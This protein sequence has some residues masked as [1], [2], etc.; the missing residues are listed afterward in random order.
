MIK[1]RTNWA[2]RT[3]AAVMTAC[4]VLTTPGL[5]RAENVTS[6][7]Y[8]TQETANSDVEA[9]E[10]TADT[11]EEYTGSSEADTTEKY[12]GGSEAD[13]TEIDTDEPGTE[14][15]E[16]DT[17]EEG[18][19]EED[20]TEDITEENTTEEDTAEDTT[21]EDT[22]E[23]I[24]EEGTTE[25]DTA[26]NITEEDITE[27]PDSEQDAPDSQQSAELADV[28][29]PSLTLEAAVSMS[30]NKLT[31]SDQE[32]RVNDGIGLLLLSNVIPADYKN[33]VI[34]LVT[35]SGWDV[36]K[37][38]KVGGKE[39]SFLGLGS[40]DV[41]FEGTFKIDASTA[42][43]NYSI[44]TNRTLFNA[45]S[46]KAV[47]GKLSISISAEYHTIDGA[48]L[49]AVLKADAAEDGQSTLNS[50]IVLR[51]GGTDPI[52]EAIVG[53]GMIGTMEAGTSAN[54][55]FENTLTCDLRIS[56]TDNVG[57]FCNTME[58]GASL[59]AEYKK[60]AV[61]G[62]VSVETTGTDKNAGG[63]VGYM[64]TGTNLIIA[65]AS[66]NEVRSK[67][68]NAGGIVGSVIDG[69]LTVKQADGG[70]STPGFAF[71]DTLTLYAGDKSTPDNQKSA[72]GLI[73]YYEISENGEPIEF[74][75]SRYTFRK[76]EVNC[77]NATEGIAFVGGLFGSLIN[78]C[79]AERNISI[80]SA[81]A[82]TINTTLQTKV[83]DLGGMIGQ[84]TAAS[85]ESTLA[86]KGSADT[87]K[88]INVVTD[89]A[90]KINSNYG[91]II[92]EIDNNAYVEIDDVYASTTNIGS[93]S[94]AAFGGLIGRIKNGLLNA[95]NVTL[96]S[97]TDI[98]VDN[99]IGRGGLVG[100]IEKGVLRL[101]GTTDL[102]GQKITTA[103]N[104]TG[105]IV[106]NNENGLIY[107]VGDGNA[108]T[109]GGNGWSL[110][111]YNGADRG[112]SD[113]GNWGAVVRLGGNLTEGDAGVLSFGQDT[114]TVTIHSGTGADIKNANEFAAYALAFDISSEYSGS[115]G[116]LNFDSIVDK[117]KTQTVALSGD[118]YLTGTGIVGIGKDSETQMFKGAFDGGNH[119]ITLDI[120]TAYGK[121]ELDNATAA[122][123]MYVK[124]SDQR[125]AHYS[126]AMIPFSK[127]VTVS[128]VIIDGKINCSISKNVSQTTDERWPAFVSSVLGLASGTTTL[129]NVI[130]RTGI[131]VTE[132]MNAPKFNIW[133]SG[134]VGRC[135]GTKLDVTNCTW[136]SSSSLS[137][138]RDK[139]EH[140]IGGLA[141]EVMGG[142]TVTVKN[143]TL[144]GTITSKST[145][146][147]FVGG[148]IAVSRGETEGKINN[149][150][151]TIK[152]SNVK[153]D[154][155]KI[156]A[157]ATSTCGGLLGY[158]WQNTNVVFETEENTGGVT[159]SGSTLTAQSAQFGGLVYQAS[160]YWNATARDS[161]VFKKDGKGNGNTFTGKS[162]KDNTSGLLVGTGIVKFTQNNREIT[163]AMYLEAGTWGTGSDDS[164]YKINKDAVTLD[165]GSSDY[166]DE[167]VGITEDDETGS[168]N[169][170][171]SLAVRDSSG[172]AVCIDKEGNNTYKGQIKNYKNMH[173]RYYYNLDSYRKNNTD[174]SLDNISKP[175]NLVLWSVSQYAA[176][177]IRTYFR[178]SPTNTTT[179]TNDIDLTGY[180]YYPVTPLCEVKVGD[181]S[182]DTV[183]TF[184]YESMNAF[185]NDNKLLSDPEHQHHLM[186]HGLL[187]NVVQN[188]TVNKMTMK[189]SV[190]KDTD[191]SGALIFGSVKGDTTTK[192][193]VVTLKEVTL[194]GIC[195]ADI[196]E[197][198]TYAPL[199][200]NRMEQAVRLAVD[201]LS[202]GDGYTSSSYAATSLIG[203]V[204]SATATKLTLS[205]S[206]I[207]LDGR[208]TADSAK[209]TCVYN[210]GT[211]KVEYHTTHTIFTRATLMESF[212]YSS[213]GSGSYNFNSDD[214]MVTYGVELTNSGTVGR[215]PDMQYQYYDADVYIKD[216]QN[217]TANEA[218]VKTRYKDTVFLRYV[219]FQ[220]NITTGNYELDINQRSSGLLEGC[221]TYGDPY[222]I[223][224]A[225]QLT[226]LAAYIQS[227]N[228]VSKFQAV[229]NSK[230]IENQSQTEDSYHVQVAKGD[231]AGT[232]DVY[233]WESGIWKSGAEKT[234]DKDTATK[235]LLNAYYKINTDITLSAEKFSGLGTSTEPFSGVIV[236]DSPE[237]TISF[238]GTANIDSFAG[239]VAY[240]RG[241]VVKDLTVDFTNA[242]ITMQADRLPGI[243]KN[244]FFGGVVGYCMGGDTIIDHVS[245]NYGSGSVAFVGTYGYM[246]AAGGYVGLVG[247]ATHVTEDTDYEKTG[248]GV[249]FRNMSGTTN[250][251]TVACADA[252]KANKTVNM[253]GADG[254]ADGKTATDGGDY[255]Y[256]NPYVGR[257][258]DGYACAEGCTVDNTDK[259]YT[260]PTL[261]KDE[262]AL[263]VTDKGTN[264]D[265]T[266]TSAQ[267]LWLLSAIVN[268]GAGAMDSTGNYTDVGTN[269]MVD[270]YQYGKPRTASYEG[271]GTDAVDKASLVSDEK[272]WG[273]NA[274][275]AG[276][277]AAE[278]RVSYLVKNYTTGTAAARL[279]GKSSAE[280][281]IP[282]NLTFDVEK[283]DMTSYGNGF[284]GIGGSYGENKTVWNK[285]CTIKKTYRRNLLVKSI[286][287]D[288]KSATTITLYMNQNDYNEE[289]MKG[290][291]INRGAG[292]FV[293]F[294][295]IDTCTVKYL[296]L[297][298]NIKVGLYNLNNG[299]ASL[300]KVSK[301]DTEK[302]YP[303]CVG[304]FA[305]RTANSKGQVT[306][307]YL[308]LESINVYGGSM[309]GGAIG[310]IDGYNNNNARNVTFKNWSVKDENVLKW[311]YNDGSAGGLVGWNVGYGKLTINNDTSETPNV[312]NLTVTTLS[313]TTD[314][315]EKTTTAAGGLV[316]A[317]DY[318]NVF[319][320]NVNVDNLTVTGT[321]LRDAGGLI[322]GGRNGNGKSV[323]VTA[324]RMS[325]ITVMNNQSNT[326][327]RCTG[328]IIGYHNTKLTISDVK[329][330]KKSTI[331]GRQYTGGFVGYSGGHVEI[332][333]CQ[334]D[335]TDI[336]SS[337]NNW[338][339]GFI[340]CF[341]AAKDT[342]VFK[343]CQ[344]KDVNILGRYVGGLTG[345]NK[346]NI[347]ASNMEFIGIRV[348]TRYDN[349]YSAG[350]LTGYTEK[351][352]NVVVSGYNILASSCKVGYVKV[353]NVESLTPTVKFELKPKTGLWVGDNQETNK[354]TLVA[355]STDGDIF[356]QKDI[357]TDN[358]TTNIVYADAP[359][360]TSYQPS[361]TTGTSYTS[362]NPWMDVNPKSDVLFADG[363][364]MTGNAVGTGTA[365]SI[366][367]EL[368]SSS[369]ALDYYWNLKDNKTEIVKFLD[370]NSDAYLTTYKAEESTTTTVSENVDF[371]VLVVN[372]TGDVDTTIWNYIAAMTNVNARTTAKSQVKNVTA[373]TYRWN[374][375]SFVQQTK[376]SLSVSTA[377]KISITPNA[378][379]NQNSQFTLLDVTYENPTDKSKVFHL[380]IPVL[381]K[382]VLYID[383]DAKFLAG[384]DYC[385]ADYPAKGQEG[386]YATAGF[387]E[388]LT[389]YMEYSYDKDTDW[390]SMLDNGENLLWYYGKQLNL[391]E[392]SS[393]DVGTLLPAGTKLTLVDRQTTQYYTYTTGA[394]EDVHSFDLSKLTAPDGTAFSPVYICDL[395]GLKAET[396]D[397]GDS[398]ST[399]YVVESEKAKATIRIGYT[400]YRKA[401]DKDTGTKY[402]ITADSDL[403]KKGCSESYYLTVQIP[404]SVSVINNRLNY[405]A[406]TRKNGALPA[407]IKSD[408]KKSGSSYVIYNGVQQ[409]LTVSTNRVH[410]R[411]DMADTVME[412]GDGIK[413]KLDSKLKLTEAGNGR[414]DKLGPSEFYHQF[415]IGLKEYI[416]NSSGSE[417]IIGTEN[418]K[419]VYSVSK[420]NKTIYTVS[421]SIQNAAALENLSIQYGSAE[422]KA[423]LD[424]AVNDASAVTVTAEVILTY[425]TADKFP[426]RNTSDGLDVSGISPVLT[427]RI[428]NTGTQL[429]IATGGNK[430]TKDDTKRYYTANQTKAMLT[431]TTVDET[432]VGDTTQQLGI[433]P[434]DE[435]NVVDMICTRADYDYTNVD[436][437]ILGRAKTISYKLELFQKDASGTYDESKPLTIGTY[438]QDGGII[439][440]DAGN[441][442]KIAASDNCCTWRENFSPA[443]EKHQ[444]T[445]IRFAPITGEEFEKAGY[446]YSNYRVR[447]TV[448]LVD[449][450]GAEIPGTK[451]SD[452]IIYT[453]ARIYQD[454]IEQ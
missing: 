295:Y 343:N 224:D 372:N 276:S 284:R 133:Q 101:H 317:C 191:N 337:S 260:I 239:L 454:L 1:R 113:I 325:N 345:A 441:E 282:V 155:E 126:L 18:I 110:I 229:F 146:N 161:I 21:E 228:S 272:Y 413:I 344:E 7:E 31:V 283:I 201:T 368:N 226:S 286:N 41:P 364:V 35:T 374:E 358:G 160:G 174:L 82:N 404:E 50:D 6:E 208:K 247:G 26:E 450:K 196:Q 245:V 252:A 152:I 136:G 150:P 185:E 363:M 111:R 61:G 438:M 402:K 24:T 195:V 350:L 369:P 275:V 333:A 377:K 424:T 399:Y 15:T 267:G 269:Q 432:G 19:T 96:A 36:T 154:G 287:Y 326:N 373:S 367:E 167:L 270:A 78:N 178:K 5:A 158:K 62:S 281:N 235:Y 193:V 128:D 55:T 406:V 147:A 89:G 435:D 233:T 312:K 390:Q 306:F 292:L 217:K 2:K 316:G 425:D 213:S 17:T 67:A 391:A 144:S 106:G 279:A 40:S 76:F 79:P 156:I 262:N 34:N 81:A 307:E 72:G 188:V 355:V 273:G 117:T 362:A 453:N 179:I 43:D 396:A 366:L 20:T 384:T 415:D 212:M 222:I 107:A 39:Y 259:N 9:V 49:S 170:V 53:G 80:S 225:L 323:T 242:T 122:G 447:L 119:K 221:G 181:G 357:G 403:T 264:L 59:T 200:I 437:E 258:L 313:D 336:Y 98:S 234:I 95:G 442:Q 137:D 74:D 115:D 314:T 58:A 237:T 253:T 51:K 254:T 23:E 32:I 189:G 186:Q 141:A 381:V 73:G 230:V 145:Q 401:E 223:K 205:F 172:S 400:Y 346:G 10:N 376:A 411:S 199:L 153:V 139:D 187:Y 341:Y 140:R 210:N 88:N 84:Y 277:D 11:T 268:S 204:G 266:V 85:K 232:D 421:G 138:E 33:K 429:P 198:D 430:V 93:N 278:N 431:Y 100:C 412:N 215:N 218:Y 361:E 90:G 47:L 321:W 324:C 25:E 159:I 202:T 192:I 354:I 375:S 380:Y 410:S 121:G 240:S 131:S 318:S 300:E 315:K 347:Q 70:T 165:I 168:T 87:G 42:S 445:R 304:G 29:A 231:A 135:Q 108:L 28:D 249:V 271:I 109:N 163:N 436:A 248:G 4:M 149:Q 322:A 180:S 340:G 114:H 120:G 389:A 261:I 176:E 393:A 359:A 246:V 294:N 356:P 280:T 417:T 8:M 22:A 309:T 243:E 134:F 397:T 327:E 330:D 60:N 63:F 440:G 207:A 151:S 219:H 75:L 30:S 439:T 227:A 382:K 194:S 130:V 102:S 105:Q 301:R 365:V 203:Y 177:N 46:T 86:I 37:P 265:V 220:Q 420:E 348:V 48:L 296:R 319:I 392:G 54:I 289:F 238:K 104:H 173:A 320:K 302:D 257:V 298:G 434:S 342:A 310:L 378:Y 338:V 352:N 45:L 129:K 27:L 64:N 395:L 118:V 349:A 13:T 291:W 162:D 274:S 418:V 443:A 416:Q 103:Y 452:Y 12:T 91:G 65:G 255:F 414:F 236:G 371:P 308:Y 305:A 244:P 329:L 423:E 446:T 351:K 449:E 132:D 116:V 3:I 290:Y 214:S 68:G 99:V 44:S 339:G 335:E 427:S 92:A 360:D 409:T 388:P 124:R 127:D 69:S 311:V 112:G 143:S 332:E 190:G 331:S 288:R 386:H 241:S 83:D 385:A 250:S 383:F 419:Y 379:D 56:G 77:D 256:C 216:E 407:A 451:T 263:Q 16:E 408:S 398:G 251:F 125:D 428:A 433:N 184:G 211:K 94:Q 197:S 405:A 71:A 169:A 175:E 422:L 97:K 183:L 328:G 157:E 123:Q 387:D 334:I 426:V 14:I 57:L 448:V 303:I 299:S 182:S 206:N 293:D 370:Q 166:F 38:V 285:D 142:C 148:M 164:S 52:S 444:F 353:S 171:V 394:D 209:S 297:S 66:V